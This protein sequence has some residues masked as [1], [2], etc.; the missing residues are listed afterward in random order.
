MTDFKYKNKK[1]VITI[2]AEDEQKSKSIL[3]GI[4]ESVFITDKN[5]KLI[6]S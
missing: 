3:E 4:L 5:F 2:T 1:A 6:K